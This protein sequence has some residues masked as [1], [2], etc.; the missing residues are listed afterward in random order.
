[1][2]AQAYNPLFIC[3]PPGVGKTH[4]LSSIANLLL[5]HSPGLTVRCT[6]GE[7]FTNEFLGAL[8]DG[9][10]PTPSRRASATSTCCSLD[11]VQ[12]LERKT[13]APRRSSSTPST[14]STTAAARSC[15]PPTA[16]RTTCRRSRTA[17][18]SASRPGSSP[19]SARPTS[20]RGSRS[21]ASAPTTTA[22]SSPTS[23][24][25]EVIAERVESNVRA[26]EGALIRVVAFSSLTG[27]P[28]DRASSPREVLGE[29]L[30]PHASARRRAAHDRRHP[31]RGLRA[32]RH[33]RRG[34]ALERAHR[35]RRLAAAGRHVPRA[36]AHRR[37]AAGDR[38][39]SSAGATTR[40]CS[41]PAGA[42]ARASPPTRARVR[43]WRSCAQTCGEHAREPAA[44]R[45]TAQPER[46][47]HCAPQRVPPPLPRHARQH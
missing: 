27:R 16:R 7:A 6:T 11:D 44:P 29:P 28:L 46:L 25:L 30:P 14:R 12:F 23:D 26:L 9:A 42:P 31:G 2:P 1:M 18:A 17:C 33:L 24:A 15:S 4:L 47:P 35:T 19:T 8:G 34:A 38:P 5:A 3:G 20:P 32:L 45:P 10:A 40:P 39:A 36:R 43:L 41:T 13:Q 22:S 37:V 21:C